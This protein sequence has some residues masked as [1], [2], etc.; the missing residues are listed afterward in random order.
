MRGEY[1]TTR[2]K[3]LKYF[4]TS[5][6][7]SGF[8]VGAS[9][10]PDSEE[11]VRKLFA[12]SRTILEQSNSPTAARKFLENN[13]FNVSSRTAKVNGESKS[14]GEARVKNEAGTQSTYEP[15]DELTLNLDLTKHTNNNQYFAS[16][17]WMWENPTLGPLDGVALTYKQNSWAV[18]QNGYSSSNYV[19]LDTDAPWSNG[20]AW[21][22]KDH[23]HTVENNGDGEWRSASLEID[24]YDQNV[25][26]E[27][28]YIWLVYTQSSSPYGGLV[29]GL[30]VGYGLLT[31][32]VTGAGMTKD[33]WKRDKN[34]N[35]LKL[36]EADAGES[37][38]C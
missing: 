34:G 26:P 31:V 17:N 30:G 1:T 21:R 7:V 9:A 8:S 10:R 25:D 16:A 11:Q 6:T 14:E 32:N 38:C 3:V 2:R 27:D 5:A 24:P 18:P 15:R 29:E 35:D 37:R 20:Y 23:K 33:T 22:Y 4:G 13:G 12:Q 19:S 36:S 28:R